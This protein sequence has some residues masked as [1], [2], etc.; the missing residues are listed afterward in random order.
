M[1]ILVDEWLRLLILLLLHVKPVRK[2]RL[3]LLR[4]ESRWHLLSLVWLVYTAVSGACCRACKL[5]LLRGSRALT[6]GVSDSGWG[7]DLGP[8]K[9]GST[10]LLA[11]TA[12]YRSV[13]N[14][15]NGICPT[16]LR[17]GA[18]HERLVTPCAIL[19]SLSPF[20]GHA[21]MRLRVTVF[22]VFRESYS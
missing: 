6:A 3:L 21:P 10:A 5:P 4:E 19:A 22:R 11:G 14:S 13:A 2:A 18:G 20:G 15:A 17:I 16:S 9:S 1:A 12:Y 7:C 8:A